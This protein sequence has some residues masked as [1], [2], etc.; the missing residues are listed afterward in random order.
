VEG[1]VLA[2][3]SDALDEAYRGAGVKAEKGAEHAREVASVLRRGR[4]ARCG[5]RAG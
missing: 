5:R 2:D 1:D 4:G 3:A